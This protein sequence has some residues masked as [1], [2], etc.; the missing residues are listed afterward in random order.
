[1][2]DVNK[3]RRFFP[4]TTIYKD[5]AVMAM[6]KSA[7]IESFLR[8]WIIKRKA[9]SNGKIQDIEKLSQYVESIIPHRNEK[10]R[11]E[12]EARTCGETRSFL[13]KINVLF[14]PNANYHSFEIVDLG[15]T[16]AHTIIEDYVW[17]RIKDEIIG[18]AG[19]WGLVKIGYMPPENNKKNGRFTLLDYKN[20]CPYEVKLEPYREARKN[21]TTEEWMDILLGAIDYNAD[22]FVREDFLDIDVWTAKHTMLTRLL[23]FI[24]SNLNLIELAP[25]QTGKSYIFGKLC[26]YGWLAGGGSISRAKLFLDMRPGAKSAG[27]VTFNDFVAID[28][29]KSIKFTNDKEMAGILK[30][31]MEDGRVK[32]G[33]VNVEGEAGIIFLGNISIEDMDGMHDM[34][35]ELPEV[36][37]DTAL[38]QRIHGFVP[39]RNIPPLSKKMFINDWALNTEYF[40]EIMHKMRTPAESMRYRGLVEELVS[41][42]SKKDDTS[43]REQEAIMRMCTAYLKLFF[44]HADEN[45]IHELSFRKDFRR[46][47]LEPAIRMQDTVLQQMKI[48]NPGEFGNRSLS[49]YKLRDDF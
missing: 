19:G 21:F 6:F 42:S 10:E 18:E 17:D 33:D 34:F 43:G 22:G 24:Q 44:P 48:I 37:R 14:H 9:D 40:T 31:Y 3:L 15:F 12:D 2:Y 32:V 28:E 45:L 20:F 11:L 1:M 5:P 7:K 35:R 39:G 25:Q 16:H 13:A 46:Y 4:A 30:G 36:F 27:L 8:D 38:I 29:I 41:V 23:P 49:T 26:K 47:C